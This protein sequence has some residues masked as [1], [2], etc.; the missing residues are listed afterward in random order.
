MQGLLARLDLQ[1]ALVVRERNVACY[2][3]RSETGADLLAV[4]GAHDACLR[5]EEHMVLGRV[6]ESANRLAN[7][8]EANARR[9]AAAGERQAMLV[10]RLMASP[11]WAALPDAL[12]DAGELRVAFPT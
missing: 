7:C 5:W 10:R 1:F 6:R 8:D 3:K 4:L 2:T 9:A 12:Q 11:G